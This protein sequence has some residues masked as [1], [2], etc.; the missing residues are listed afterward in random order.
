MI[1]EI[2]DAETAQIAI[3]AALTGHLVLSS[4]H[5]N[6][7][8]ASVTRLVEMGIEPYLLGSSLA[9]VVSQRLVRRV[10]PDCQEPHAVSKEMFRYLGMEEAEVTQGFV[11][12]KGCH[13]CNYT[14]YRGRLA[15]HEVVEFTGELREAIIRKESESRL[16]EIA[17]KQG[18]RSLK[19]DGFEKASRGLTTLEEVIQV[20][21]M[22]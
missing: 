12:G 4:I 9:G 19:Q 14:G 1:G 21:M 6:S 11:H 22:D 15:I 5:T 18:F 3:Q 20:V 10:C 8:I 16:L 17:L 13:A 7:A 2:R